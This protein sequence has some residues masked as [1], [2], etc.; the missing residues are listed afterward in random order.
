MNR[1]ISSEINPP[2]LLLCRNWKI[3]S[4]VS[5]PGVNGQIKYV[6]IPRIITTSEIMAAIPAIQ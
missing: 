4:V 3:F 2:S 5:R 1:K 6:T